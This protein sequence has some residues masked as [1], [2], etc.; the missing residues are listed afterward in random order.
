MKKK[1]LIFLLILACSKSDLKRNPYLNEVSFTYTITL[2]LPLYNDLNYAGGSIYMPFGGI[3]GFIVFNLDG[4]TFFAWEASCSNHKL[5]S[6]SKLEVIGLLANCSCEDF[7]Y[8][9]ATGQLVHGEIQNNT[10]YPLLN[11]KVEK[12]GKDL[13][14]SN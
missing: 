10:I 8:S 12:L 5:E 6:C 13:I 3:N 11:Y 9:L 14:I 4:K 7:S 2:D 1:L